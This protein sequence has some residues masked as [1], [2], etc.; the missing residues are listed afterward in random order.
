MPEPRHWYL[1]T[2]DVSEPRALRK[3]HKTLSAWGKPVQLSVFRTRCT[4][5]ELEQLRFKLTKIIDG[6]DRLMIIRLCE[7]CAS[8]VSV[9]GDLMVDFDPEPPPFQIV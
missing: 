8:R 6:A 2:Y 5:R 4:E 1:I 3:V 7:G 9:Q